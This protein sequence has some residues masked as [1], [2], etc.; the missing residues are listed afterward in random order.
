MSAA[1]FGESTNEELARLRQVAEAYREQIIEEVR[2]GNIDTDDAN[3]KLRE[4]G[5]REYGST[6]RRKCTVEF[7][8]GWEDDETAPFSSEFDQQ[9]ENLLEAI[10]EDTSYVVLDPSSVMVELS[11]TLTDANLPS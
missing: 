4:H 3:E 7:W 8:I 6:N 2:N 10:D 9:I 1:G 5:L 11:Q